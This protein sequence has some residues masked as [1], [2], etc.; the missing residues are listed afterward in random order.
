VIV[1]TEIWPALIRAAARQTVPCLIVSGRISERS[2]ARYQLIRWL[3]RAV[4]TQVDACAMQTD[5]DAVRIVD[6]GA[7]AAR[8]QV[9]G[10]LKFAREVTADTAAQPDA[11]RALVNGRPLLVAAS[12]HPG[13]EQ[14][15]IDACADLWQAFPRLL[16]LIAPRRPERFDDVDRLLAETGLRYERRTNV[17]ERVADATHVLLL[18]TIG[19]LPNV[20]ATATAVFVGG[21]VAPVGGHNVLEPAL[22]GKPVAFGPHTANVHTAAEALLEGGAAARVHDASELAAEWRRLL[23]QPALAQEVGARGRTVVAAHAAVAERT[24]AL[25]R[26]CMT[27]G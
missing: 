10:S 4:L 12:T 22:C 13:E 2:A 25:I 21:T 26:R 1:E 24:A 3:T 5:A 23:A 17:R 8:V 6:M 19:E 16:L 15:A 7:P 14:L 18:D 27:A 20:L 9:L 11:M